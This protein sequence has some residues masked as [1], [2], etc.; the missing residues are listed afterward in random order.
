MEMTGYKDHPYQIWMLFWKI[1]KGIA[2]FKNKINF[3][4]NQL[5]LAQGSN[6][7]TIGKVIQGK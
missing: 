1:S 4:L 5:K 3:E 2:Q 6:Q 7:G